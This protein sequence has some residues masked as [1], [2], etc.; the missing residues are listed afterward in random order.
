MPP[1]FAARGVTT[2]APSTAARAWSGARRS[3][4]ADRTTRTSAPNSSRRAV[5]TPPRNP[6]PPVTTTVLPCQNPAEGSD[7]A[8]TDAHPSPRQLVLERLEIGVAHDL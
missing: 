6:A 2:C 8:L 4:S 3:C 7:T 1:T 5:T